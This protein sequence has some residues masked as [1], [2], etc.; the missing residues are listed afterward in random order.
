[1][2]TLTYQYKLRPSKQQDAE[3]ERILDI[4][5]SVYNYA[6]REGKDWL[7]SRKSPINSCSIISEI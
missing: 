6:L 3:I 4:C 2:I 7:N 5:K 1:V